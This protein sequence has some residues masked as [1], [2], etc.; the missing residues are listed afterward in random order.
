MVRTIFGINDP[1][2]FWKFWNCPKMHSRVLSLSYNP[3]MKKKQKQP[4]NM[5]IYS[6]LAFQV[7]K[8]LGISLVFLI[9]GVKNLVFQNFWFEIPNI[10]IEAQCFWLKYWYFD[11]NTRFFLWITWQYVTIVFFKTDLWTI[12]LNIQIEIQLQ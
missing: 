9:Q 6:V 11:W 3:N 4:P 7:F 2:D 5:I 12:Y 1:R 8:L 10:S